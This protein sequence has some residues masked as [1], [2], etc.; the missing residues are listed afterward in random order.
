M[1]A[2]I[3]LLFMSLLQSEKWF[4]HYGVSKSDNLISMTDTEDGGFIFVGSSTTLGNGRNDLWVMKTDDSL[5]FDW[6]RFYGGPFD[7]IG[8]RIFSLDDGFL[9][10]GQKMTPTSKD[11]WTVKIDIEGKKKWE[12]AFNNRN[13]ITIQSVEEIKDSGF[14]ITGVEEVSFKDSQGLILLINENGDPIWKKTFGGSEKDGLYNTKKIKDGFVSI[15]YTNSF[16][17]SGLKIPETTFLKRMLRFF[18]SPKISQEIWLIQLDDKGN[19]M[20]EKTY[21]GKRVDIGKFVYS[22]GDSNYVI[23]GNSNS[24]K[25]KEGDVWI[26]KTDSEGKEIWSQTHGAKSKN[27]LKSS[28]QI[29]DDEILM[30]LNSVQENN[31]LSKGMGPQ[32]KNILLDK[33]GKKLWENSYPLNYSNVINSLFIFGKNRIINVGYKLIPDKKDETSF[34][35]LEG[36]DNSVQKIQAWVFDMDTL[37]VKNNEY[38]F[39]GDRSE[40]G[41]K[42]MENSQ[43]DIKVLANLNSFN[44]G[45]EDISIL[46]FDANGT[47]KNTKSLIEKGNQTGSSFVDQSDEGM[48]IIGEVY[49]KKYAGIDLLMSSYDQTGKLVWKNEYGGFGDDLGVDVIR[50]ADNGLIIAGSTNSFGKGATDGWLIKVDNSGQEQWSKSFGG[51]SLDEFYC[52]SSTMDGNYVVLGSTLSFAMNEDLYLISVDENGEDNWERT[53]GGPNSDRGKGVSELPLGGYILIGET[54]NSI[55]EN[56]KDILAIRT[57]QM[58]EEIWSLEFGGDGDQSVYDFCMLDNEGGGYVIVGET[59]S[60]AGTSKILLA[61]IS[62]MGKVLWRRSYGGGYISKGCSIKDDGSGLIVMGNLDFDENGNS[63]IF[64][65]K[66]DYEGQILEK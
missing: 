28:V 66:T 8:K 46:T 11:I 37:G 60:G 6:Q 42:I 56:G 4:R 41:I 32:T 51:K 30:T 27:N 15:G 9:I 13:D 26:I 59:D 54:Q 34:E 14:L 57:N 36:V 25:S 44:K 50:S 17:N 49:S 52:I 23:L 7:D 53:Y 1:R 47:I 38:A 31:L 48:V 58:G 45:E 18:I 3:F 43:S 63:D 21:G 5:N 65:F 10:I 22:I 16:T 19:K 55:P 29:N 24:F 33:N 39:R 12:K 40:S 62:S 20:W 2:S 64:L 61:N 35:G